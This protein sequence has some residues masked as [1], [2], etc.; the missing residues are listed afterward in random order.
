MVMIKLLATAVK[1]QMT[2]WLSIDHYPLKE[3]ILLVMD[4]QKV[5]LTCEIC[6]VEKAPTA[7]K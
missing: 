5:A 7:L 6:S 1:D 4:R 2:A 3:I